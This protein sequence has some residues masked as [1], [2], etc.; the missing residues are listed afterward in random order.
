MSM[1]VGALAE[2]LDGEIIGDRTLVVEKAQSLAK[3]GPRSVTFFVGDRNHI[4]LKGSHA[5]AILVDC[6][7]RDALKVA[8]Y[9]SCLHP[10]RRPE[11]G[12]SGS[13]GSICHAASPSANRYFDRRLRERDGSDRQEHQYSSWCARGRGSGY[14]RQLRYPSGRGRQS[15]LPAR[16]RRRATS[17][18]RAL[19][20]H[21]RGKPRDHSRGGRDRSG[22]LQLSPGGRPSRA[23]C[24]LRNGADR[25]RRRDWRLHDDRPRNDRRNGYRSGNEDR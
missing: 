9:P 12:I 2:W 20:R 11:R 19:R 14:R 17:E 18:R 5:T 13:R 25:R 7:L 15:R 22:R 21:R 24:A 16:R 6:K 1:T 4:Q 10:R 3:A 8:G 23:D